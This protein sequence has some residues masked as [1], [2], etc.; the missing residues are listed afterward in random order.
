LPKQTP[1]ITLKPI[2]KSAPKPPSET[3]ITNEEETPTKKTRMVTRFSPTDEKYGGGGVFYDKI[4]AIHTHFNKSE[5]RGYVTMEDAN[6]NR[7][8]IALD[9]ECCRGT[10]FKRSNY[11][12]KV[13]I[14]YWLKYPL[15]TEA[16]PSKVKS[17][18]WFTKC[19]KTGNGDK[20]SGRVTYPSFDVDNVSVTIKI[21][22]TW[23]VTSRAIADSSIK[24]V[25]IRGANYELTDNQILDWIVEYCLHVSD[26]EEEALIVGDEIGHDD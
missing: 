9:K 11:D 10:T 13:L 7:R 25:T 23:A 4:F 8:A 14:T 2:T 19:S 6:T 22:V 15:S 26:M 5:F 1:T 17:H 12:N 21:L 16:V 24:E 18:F 3:R 20:I